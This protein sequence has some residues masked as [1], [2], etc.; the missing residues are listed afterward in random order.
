MRS[1]IDRIKLWRVCCILGCK[2]RIFDLWC[3]DALSSRPYPRLRKKVTIQ[4]RPDKNDRVVSSYL[5]HLFNSFPSKCTKNRS[6]RDFLSFRWSNKEIQVHADE[7]SNPANSVQQCRSLVIQFWSRRCMW[8]RTQS[9]KTAAFQKNSDPDICC[10]Q[11]FVAMFGLLRGLCVV[12]DDISNDLWSDG[13]H[14][15]SVAYSS[16]S[17]GAI[18]GHVVST[19][20]SRDIGDAAKSRRRS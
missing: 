13:L 3:T 14:S 8:L 17:S 18:Q 9:L 11:R 19:F 15:G 6:A 12:E 1:V 10:S 20:F 4:N 16:G 5:Y 7:C 2:K